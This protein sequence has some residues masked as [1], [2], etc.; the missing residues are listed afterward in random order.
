MREFGFWVIMLERNEIR[1]RVDVHA[2]TLVPAML[3][4]RGLA[5][6]RVDLE[7]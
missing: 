7:R 6:I 3:L 2:P 1:R 5:G 4:E